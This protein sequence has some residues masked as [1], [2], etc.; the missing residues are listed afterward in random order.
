MAVV[1]ITAPKEE[2]SINL[3]YVRTKRHFSYA[4][5]CYTLDLSKVSVPKPSQ[6]I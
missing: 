1:I 5:L 2:L 6:V 3:S 4:R